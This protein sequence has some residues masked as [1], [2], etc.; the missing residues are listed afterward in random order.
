MV[1]WAL[2]LVVVA[3]CA[4]TA[5]QIDHG[6]RAVLQT[7][8]ALGPILSGVVV[9]F[10]AYVGF[11]NL[12]FIAGEFRNPRRDFPLAMIAAFLVY[13]GLALALTVLIAAL[14]PRGRVS[15]L[16]GLFS[17]SWPSVSP[18]PG[19]PP[20]S[21]WPSRSPSCNSTPPAGSG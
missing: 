3:L 15:A 16:S 17:S 1:S 10:W 20:A 7:V 13:G 8:R 11:E 5:P 14:I 9:A 4:L 6:Y 18:R 12:T 21:W 19:S 2:L